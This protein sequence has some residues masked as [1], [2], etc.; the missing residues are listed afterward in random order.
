MLEQLPSLFEGELIFAKRAVKGL[1]VCASFLEFYKKS[2]QSLRR[3]SVA[4]LYGSHE[5]MI[6][7]K[8]TRGKRIPF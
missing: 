8:R 3:D 4:S 1:E 6:T 7:L 5:R 2:S